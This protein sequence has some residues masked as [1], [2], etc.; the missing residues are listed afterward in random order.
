MSKRI[1][2]LGWCLL[3][4][5]IIFCVGVLVVQWT[6]PRK[7]VVVYPP[8][9]TPIML[10]T[11]AADPP[12]DGP[13]PTPVQTRTTA[14]TPVPLPTFAPTPA[15]T[16]VPT[17]IPTPTPSPTPSWPYPIPA[18]GV[19]Y[20]SWYDE[21]SRWGRA[22][23]DPLTPESI[24]INEDTRVEL[25]VHVHSIAA[26][27]RFIPY[28]TIIYIEEFEKYFIVTDTTSDS[29]LNMRARECEANGS[30]FWIDLFISS[31]DINSYPYIQQHGLGRLR[32]RL[33]RWGYN[34]VI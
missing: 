3:I 23:A 10:H 8:K 5:L 13:I 15:P 28:G 11:Y 19:V 2:C 17:P 34:I 12:T 1:K 7:T 33:I 6:S 4:A 30:D 16:P 9:P 26:D 24:S 22:C 18:Q 20:Y 21:I 14:R 32:Y 31:T 29:L 27:Y 25:G